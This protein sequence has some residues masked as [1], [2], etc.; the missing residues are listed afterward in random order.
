MT[1]PTLQEQLRRFYTP[2]DIDKQRAS[3]EKYWSL[4]KIDVRDGIFSEEDLRAA[5][6]R[7][8]EFL[9]GF[10]RRLGFQDKVKELEAKLSEI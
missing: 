10:S 3:Y 5:K 9:I 6:R 4:A 2:Q 8:Y 7:G 1:T